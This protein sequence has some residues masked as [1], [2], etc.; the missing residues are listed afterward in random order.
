MPT[1]PDRRVPERPVFV[2]ASGRRQRRVRRV[3]RIL[4]VP[5]VAYVGLLVST[6]LGGPTVNSP[7][8]PLPAG[9]HAAPGPRGGPHSVT[10]G[11]A[12]GQDGAG[13]PGTG[14]GTGGTATGASGTAPTPGVSVGATPTAG[15]TP[16]AT[17]P[18]TGASHGHSTHTAVPPGASHRPTKKAKA[19]A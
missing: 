4:V 13:G 16:S 2:D 12:Q 19:Q 18:A 6:L 15:A 5:A 9:P 17:Q 8:L 11:G 7:Y 10:R 14:S 1:P 3:G